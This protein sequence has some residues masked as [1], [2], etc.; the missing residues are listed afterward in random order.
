MLSFGISYPNNLAVKDKEIRLPN[1]PCL[2]LLQLSSSLVK[3]WIS[4]K[5][6]LLYNWGEGLDRRGKYAPFFP[7]PQQCKRNVRAARSR[8]PI[9]VIR[10]K[11]H[12]CHREKI[13]Y[14]RQYCVK[15]SF[16]QEGREKEKNS[17][18]ATRTNQKEKGGGRREGELLSCQLQ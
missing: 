16:V 9:R 14:T 4:H 5:L 1:T 11:L 15:I 6:F 2:P 13:D 17:T 3:H 10:S 12:F 8:K 18:E 7:L